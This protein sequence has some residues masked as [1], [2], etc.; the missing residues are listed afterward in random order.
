MYNHLS[1][2]K[3]A[4]KAKKSL[5]FTIFTRH[6]WFYS[7][8]SSSFSFLTWKSLRLKSISTVWRGHCYYCK[9]KWGAFKV[10]ILGILGSGQSL[11]QQ[12]R[13]TDCVGAHRNGASKN[14]SYPQANQSH[15][16]RFSSSQKAIRGGHRTNLSNLKRCH[17]GFP[18]WLSKTY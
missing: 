8:F 4:A 17:C 9:R 5:T 12:K 18:V 3:K 13:L 2:R 11:K 14:T 7:S 15:T 1:D 6:R 10:S 16:P